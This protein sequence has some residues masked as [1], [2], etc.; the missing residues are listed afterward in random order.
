VPRTSP[1]LPRSRGWRRPHP[2]QWTVGGFALAILVGTLLLLLPISRSGPGG[3]GFIEAFFTAVSAICVTG[4]V[5]VETSTY[6]S[7]FG[8]VIIML[9][10]QIGGFGVMTFASIIGIAVVRRLSLASRLN[11]AAET[12]SFGLEDVRSLVLN[13][14]RISLV[15][16][17]AAA[18]ILFLW[19]MLYYGRSPGEAAWQAIFHAVTSFNNA[20]FS[21][22]T[23]TSSTTS[24]IPS[25]PS[26]SRP[27]SS[28]AASASR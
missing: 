9:L 1:V 3:A 24:R 5:I 17:G 28:S 18:L 15:I 26:R 14:L 6:W 16:E 25:S 13:V 7:G 10:V 20:G 11:A 21:I 22:F 27:R 8:Q 23:G 19:F 12:R 2:A 4:H